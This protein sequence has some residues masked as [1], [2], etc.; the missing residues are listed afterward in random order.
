MDGWKAN[1]AYHKMVFKTWYKTQNIGCISMYKLELKQR[2]CAYTAEHVKFPSISIYWYIHMYVYCV[3]LQH[4]FL[5]CILIMPMQCTILYIYVCVRID[6][7]LIYLYFGFVDNNISQ[8]FNW[9][10]FE[11]YI[12]KYQSLP[13]KLPNYQTLFWYT[14]LTNLR[15]N[16]HIIQNHS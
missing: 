1:Q 7:N 9:Y 11:L 10:T 14:K 15:S 13:T 5:M 3:C 6:H 12:S 4:T 2:Y 16:A 8:V